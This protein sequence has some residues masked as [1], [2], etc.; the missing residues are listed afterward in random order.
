MENKNTREPLDPVQVQ[1]LHP[2][3]NVQKDLLSIDPVATQ[4]AI[5]QAE[6]EYTTASKEYDPCRDLEQP[7]E[8]GGFKIF[9]LSFA[10]KMIASKVVKTEISE[11]E[12]AMV[13]VY[14]LTE[15]DYKRILKMSGNKIWEKAIEFAEES[16]P[17]LYEKLL[18]AVSKEMAKLKDAEE[19]GIGLTGNKTKQLTQLT[20]EMDGPEKN[21]G[22]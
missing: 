12:L 19:V 9:P 20:D 5:Q 14:I 13:M 1:P 3:K 2:V 18:A 7:D 21:V 4:A 22:T 10:R 11:E 16:E 15:K 6:V 17:K 8:V